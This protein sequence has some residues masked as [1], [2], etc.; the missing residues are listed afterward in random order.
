MSLKAHVADTRNKDCVV[1]YDR[2]LKI[3]QPT[4]LKELVKDLRVVQK[5]VNTALTAIIEKEKANKES[6]GEEREEEEEEDEEEPPD[7]KKSKF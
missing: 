2:D 7:S 1:I 3:D 6:C 5:E 4:D